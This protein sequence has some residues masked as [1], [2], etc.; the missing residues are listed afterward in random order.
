MSRPFLTIAFPT[1]K[2]YQGIWAS[3]GALGLYHSDALEDCEVLVMDNG[4][5]DKDSENLTNWNW[6]YCPRRYVRDAEIIGTAYAKDACV[7]HAKGEF[8]LVMDSHVMLWP[9]ALTKLKEYLQNVKYP[10]PACDDFYTGPLIYDDLKA[11]STH[12][13]DQWRG[14]MW[15]TW[16]T[17]DRGRDMTSPP[18]EI[19]ANGNGLFCVRK[20]SWPGMNQYF[21]GFGGEEWYIHEKYRRLGRKVMCLPFLRWY[22]RFG[23]SNGRPYDAVTYDKVRNGVLCLLDLG[24]CLDRIKHHFVIEEQ[25]GTKRSYITEEQWDLLVADPYAYKPELFTPGYK[26]P[27]LYEAVK[28][29]CQS[30]GDNTQSTVAEPINFKGDQKTLTLSELYEAVHKGSSDTCKAMQVV[31][32]HCSGLNEILLVGTGSEKETGLLLLAAMEAKPKRV[33]FYDSRNIPLLDTLMRQA[34]RKVHVERLDEFPTPVQ[35]S[36]ADLAVFWQP[37]AQ[38]GSGELPV[39]DAIDPK[40]FNELLVLN[41]TPENDP[42]H[43]LLSNDSAWVVTQAERGFIRISDDQSKKKPLPKIS[44]QIRNFAATVGKHLLA[45]RGKTSPEVFEQRISICNLCPSRNDDKCAECGCYL[46]EKAAIPTAYCP[47]YKWL[48]EGELPVIEPEKKE[49]NAVP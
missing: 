44:T 28:S 14:E 37:Y 19:P 31:K 47:L 43:N 45:G 9:D 8:V 21:R 18:F 13:A 6:E 26:K 7:R 49:T 16:D 3:V 2:D 23:P 29:G 5:Y 11:I 10:A 42:L 36:V 30:C 38:L 46:A 41:V 40:F 1:F 25:P 48:G 27:V 4:P 15:G 12:F 20:D 33:R 22:H 32:D 17:D 24:L 39:T 35:F 34:D